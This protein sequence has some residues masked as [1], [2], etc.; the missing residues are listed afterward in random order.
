MALVTTR[1]FVLS[2]IVAQEQSLL[3]EFCLQSQSLMGAAVGNGTNLQHSYSFPARPWYC[4]AN[5]L[6]SQMTVQFKL[7]LN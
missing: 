6:Q 1:R 4:A 3:S 2:L 7:L 5:L